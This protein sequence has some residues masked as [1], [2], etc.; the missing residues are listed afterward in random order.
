MRMIKENVERDVDD[1]KYKKFIEDGYKPVNIS[2][3]SVNES[4]EESIAEAP[5]KLDGMNLA[6]LRAVAK[7]QGLSGYSSLSKEELFNILKG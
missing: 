7:E 4:L 1:S 6:E 2:G 3:D 5:K